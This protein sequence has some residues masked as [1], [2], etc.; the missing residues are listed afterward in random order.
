MTQISVEV[1][2]PLI[3]V[4]IGRAMKMPLVLVM[5]AVG[6]CQNTDA[7]PARDVSTSASPNVTTGASP[8]ASASSATATPSASV[9]STTDALAAASATTTAA[10]AASTASA[11]GDRVY[12][13][14]STAIDAKVGDHFSVVVPGNATSSYTWKADPKI[15]ATVLAVAD[16][17][18]TP[19]PPPGCNGQ[20][21]GYGGTYSFP[22]TASAAG[23]TK[24]HLVKVHVG[25]SPGT[26]VQ[27]VSITVTVK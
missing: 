20:C 18:Y 8:K 15:D 9:A 4:Q 7:P 23:S 25:R 3:G 2:G 17:K 11:S 21:L 10:P 22:V 13:Q 27:E 26:P 14:T 16:P 1:D 5:L 6:A 12:D 24:L 19:Q